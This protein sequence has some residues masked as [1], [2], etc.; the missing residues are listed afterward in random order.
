MITR[1]LAL[2]FKKGA[3]TRAQVL[4]AIRVLKPEAFETGYAE[5]NNDTQTRKA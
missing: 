5:L 2:G 3:T 1:I 4:V